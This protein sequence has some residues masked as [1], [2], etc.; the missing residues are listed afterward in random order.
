MT[1][2][3]NDNILTLIFYNI[4]LL[5]FKSALDM[6]NKILYKIIL[7]L[8][9]FIFESLGNKK[10]LFEISKKAKN[11]LTL[12]DKYLIRIDYYSYYIVEVWDLNNNQRIKKFLLSDWCFSIV[13]LPNAKLATL[14][15]N[16]I[17]IW[18]INEDFKQ[19]QT[20]NLKKGYQTTNGQLLILSNGDLACTVE[21]K[22]VGYIFIFNKDYKLH[23]IIKAHSERITCIINL[24]DN[25]FATA[26]GNK[27]KLWKF[28]NQKIL[29]FNKK[30]Y[31]NIQAFIGQDII[32]NIGLYNRD[33]MIVSSTKK[34]VVQLWNVKYSQCIK[35]IFV[36]DEYNIICSLVLHNGFIAFGTEFG[37]VLIY[38]LWARK[39]VKQLKCE[40]EVTCLLYQ[41]NKLI[42]MGKVKIMI[43]G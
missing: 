39:F 5:A 28:I 3:S 15:F 38:D 22:K 30:Y 21:N 10:K 12:T 6:P 36:K 34:G 18:D 16:S 33:N 19:T 4:N 2:Y 43:W 1:Y 8:R 42:S 37:G 20:I 27:I 26:A 29:F 11:I 41:E 32:A 40:D 9:E 35:T 31:N 13:L 25:M 17:G 14:N 7:K 23:N 24:V